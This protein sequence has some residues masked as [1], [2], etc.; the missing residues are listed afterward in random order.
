MVSNKRTSSNTQTRDPVQPSSNTASTPVTPSAKP[1]TS[2]SSKNA[3]SGLALAS[4]VW[5]NYVE[6]TAQRT[7][8]IDVFLAFLVVVGGLQFV[9]CILVGNYVCDLQSIYPLEGKAC[10]AKRGNVA[11]V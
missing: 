1:K 2:S 9:Y 4:G 10:W 6:N 3:Q 7:K 5:N 11:V 8:L